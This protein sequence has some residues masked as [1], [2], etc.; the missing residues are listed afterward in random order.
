LIRTIGESLF[1]ALGNGCFR[2]QV[3]DDK[4]KQQTVAAPN[5]RASLRAKRGNPAVVDG[6]LHSR[7][8]YSQ[9]KNSNDLKKLLK[10]CDRPP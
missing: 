8:K 6:H 5:A 4:T 10:V 9:N 2:I 3:F 1:L 7:K